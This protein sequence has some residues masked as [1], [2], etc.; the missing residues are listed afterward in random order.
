MPRFEY[1]GFSGDASGYYA[2]SRQLI[3][4]AAGPTG[5]A[6]AVGLIGVLAGLVVAVRR[7]R[8][9]RHWALVAGCLALSTAVAVIVAR[10]SAPGAAV[11]GWSLVWS[12]PLVPLRGV[13]ALREHL[14]F[15]V[16]VALSLAGIAATVVCTA[17]IGRAATGR[18]WVGVAAAALFAFWP[19]LVR[20]VAGA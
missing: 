13:G 6:V 1:A 8:L 7:R 3:S 4:R 11:I 17:V 18:R 15:D 20:P 14:A 10:M 5:A 19:L 16:S 12:V 2:A 9:A